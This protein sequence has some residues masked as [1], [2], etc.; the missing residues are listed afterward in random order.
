MVFGVMKAGK[1]LKTKIK[2]IKYLGT[3]LFS[4]CSQEFDYSDLLTKEVII[5]LGFLCVLKG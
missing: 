2:I 1:I 3:A 4:P 5:I